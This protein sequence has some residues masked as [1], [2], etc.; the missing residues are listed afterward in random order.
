MISISITNRQYISYIRTVIGGPNLGHHSLGS[1]QLQHQQLTNMHWVQS[2][3]HAVLVKM[4][5]FIRAIRDYF[6]TNWAIVERTYKY[7][8]QFELHWVWNIGILKVQAQE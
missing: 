5:T 7:S 2:A 1:Q 6:P 3:G 4:R 8:I